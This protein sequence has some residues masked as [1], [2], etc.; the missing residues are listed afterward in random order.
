[1]DYL[2]SSVLFCC[3]Y[4]AVRSPMA[5][6]IMKRFHG[7]LVFVDS[8]G[9]HVGE[10]DPF[11]VEVMH[12]IGVDMS[13]H[14]PKTFDQ[15]ADDSFDYVISLSPH[16][17]HKAVDLTRFMACEVLFWN[18]YDPTLADGA[19]E[20]RLTAYR[21]VRDRLQQRILDIFPKLESGAF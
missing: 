5:E 14:Q 10:L 3:T 6:G 13:K 12:E 7:D 20:S 15:L 9:V 18:T 17:Q 11:V 2:P 21:A 4:N 19:R 1:M 8:V 16:A